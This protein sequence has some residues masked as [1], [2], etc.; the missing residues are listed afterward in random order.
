MRRRGFTLVEL[1]VVIAIIAILLAILLPAVQAS[2]EAARATT[3]K[4]SLRQ[5]AIAADLFYDGHQ[6]Y[7]TGRHLGPYGKGPNSTAW[8][9]IALMLP[10]IDETALYKAGNVPTRTLRASGIA[11]H[12]IALLRCPSDTGITADPATDRGDLDGFAVGLSNYKGVCG[13]NWGAD[14]S[15]EESEIGTDWT[16]PGTNGSFDGQ[17]RGDGIFNRPDYDHP[18]RKSDITDGLSKTFMFGE[19]L[20]NADR[21]A[22]SWCY[23]NGTHGT[24]AIPPN[25]I[26]K[27]GSDYTP[28]WW[29]N[30]LSFRSAHPG[31]VHFALADER[32]LFISDLIDLP[33][34]RGT[35]TIAGKE[36]VD[37]TPWGR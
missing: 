4:N 27:E 11:D 17:T 6:H 35:A 37:L 23:G 24:C 34:Y 16:N 22:C 28:Y 10:Y 13:A 3:C 14:E 31:G 36:A 25:V 1:L 18:R 15:I 5:L 29:P 9:R 21:W 30:V 20:P 7:P 12:H 32:V 8:S 33:V 2:R 26:P 19:D